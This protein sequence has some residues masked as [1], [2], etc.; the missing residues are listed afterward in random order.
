MSTAAPQ[1]P[2]FTQPPRF[3]VASSPHIA[4]GDTVRGSMLDVMVALLPSLG[5]STYF[6]GP[7]VLIMTAIAMF[8][9]VFFEFLYRFAMKKHQSIGDLSACVTGML[10]AIQMHMLKVRHPPEEHMPHHTLYGMSAYRDGVCRYPYT[11]S[12]HV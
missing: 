5:V 10:L 6:F 1:K 2:D 7:R 9:C 8:S 4:S 3:T 11:A 12:R